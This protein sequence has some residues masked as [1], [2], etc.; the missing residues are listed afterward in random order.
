MRVTAKDGG[1]AKPRLPPS[2]TTRAMQELHEAM[3]FPSR[4]RCGIRWIKP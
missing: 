2:R 4:L 1:P 3:G